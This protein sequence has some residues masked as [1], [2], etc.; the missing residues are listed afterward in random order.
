MGIKGTDA[1]KEFG[2]VLAAS[3]VRGNIPK[4]IEEGYNIK[5]M[6]GKY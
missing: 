3:G 5:W 1:G 4:N 6:Q 2:R